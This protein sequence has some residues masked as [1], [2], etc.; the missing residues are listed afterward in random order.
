MVRMKMMQTL[1]FEYAFPIDKSSGDS[2]F[3]QY[4]PMSSPNGKW[5]DERSVNNEIAKYACLDSG[6][7]CGSATKE[8]S[9]SGNW[10]SSRDYRWKYKEYN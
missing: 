10:N 8:V 3:R 1:D 2:T 4:A 5:D 7:G 9:L 6:Q